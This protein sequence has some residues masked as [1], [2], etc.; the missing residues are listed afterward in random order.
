[1]KDIFHYLLKKKDLPTQDAYGKEVSSDEEQEK[2]ND[3]RSSQSHDGP[4]KSHSK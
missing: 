2:E 1:M 3:E 4:S